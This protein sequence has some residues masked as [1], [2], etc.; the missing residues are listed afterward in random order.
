[1]W[2]ISE[3]KFGAEEKC[4]GNPKRGFS[5]E[6]KIRINTTAEEEIHDEVYSGE[7]ICKVVY[8]Y[9]RGDKR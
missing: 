1:M 5:E 7:N 6:K 2:R 4:G 9:D 3:E 8:M